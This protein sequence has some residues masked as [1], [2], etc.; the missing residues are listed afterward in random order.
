[1]SGTASTGSPVLRR[2]GVASTHSQENATLN[3]DKLTSRMVCSHLELSLRD[4]SSLPGVPHGSFVI[5]FNL[6][7]LDLVC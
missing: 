6:S 1:M 5:S 4:L 2:P 3:E 7:L